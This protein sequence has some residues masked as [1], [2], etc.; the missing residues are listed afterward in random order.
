MMKQNI[1]IFDL[2]ET[3]TRKGTWGRFVASAIKDKPHKWLPFLLIG[4]GQQILYLLRFV[5]REY[6]KES[7][8]RWTITG[9]SRAAL[10]TRAHIFA[11][12]EVENGL[13]LRAGQILDSHRNTGDRLIIASAA[14]DLIVNPIADRLD[15]K[16]RVCT[17]T[18]FDD[19]DRLGRKLGGRNCHGPMKLTLVQEYLE[20]EPKFD[21]NHAHITMYSDSS[22]DLAILK[23]ADVGIAVNPGPKLR[24]LAKRHGL[25][26][27]D[28]NAAP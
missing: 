27:Q 19:K 28:W 12:E 13:R 21:R 10:E 17:A 9:H 15:I 5:P 2:D 3:L 14:V 20:R 11:K 8:M 16:D 1:A 25:E 18:E 24:K 23:W 26:I 6:V 22:S 7:M 4:I